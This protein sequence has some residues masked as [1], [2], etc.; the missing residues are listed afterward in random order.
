MS[1]RSLLF[2]AVLPILACTEPVK[3]PGPSPLGMVL[4]P[5]GVTY[6]G[7]SMV[8][9]T[10]VIVE[11]FTDLNGS[12]DFDGCLDDPIAAGEF[13]DEPFD[14]VNGNGRFD[15]VWI[16]GFG[17]LR[18]AQDVHDPIWART[19]VLSQDEQYVAFVAID[20]VGLGSPRIHE[21]K[22]RLAIDGFD[23]DRLV[24]A[25]SHNHQGPDTMGLWGDPITLSNPTSGMDPAYQERV[26]DAIE[27]SVREAAASMEPVDLRVATVL[28][29]DRSPWFNGA[30]FGG[31]N[32]KTKQHGMIND[33]RDPVVVSDQL[34]VMQ[35]MLSSG[36]AAF[37]LTNWSG[38]PETRDSNNN[39][40][41]SDWVGVSREVIEE[42]FGGMALHLPESLGGMQSALGGELPRV[43][44]DG[45]HVFATCEAEA[46]ADPDD[47]DCFGR[48]PGADR[49]DA[50]G[51]SVP[52][53]A[54]K[55]TWDFVTSHGWHIAE[56]TIDIIED[57]PTVSASPIDV[58]TEPI[59]VPIDNFAYQILGP[60]DIFDLGLDDA[61][62]DPALCPRAADSK[63]GCIETQ[64][65]QI[66]V[67]PVGFVAVPGE[68]LPELAWGFPDDAA[69]TLE[70]ADTTARGAGATY[71]PQHR[72]TC[73][74]VSFN[75]CSERTFVDG[76]DCLQLHATPY[77]LSENGAAPPLLEH[78]DTEHRAV[79]GMAD[80]Y[81]SYI[82]PRP[83]F[84]RT[85][86]L[87]WDS[88]GDHYEDTVS[89]SWDFA[90]AI[91]AA[92][93]RI[94]ARRD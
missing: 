60:H 10:P 3:A 9:L 45:V 64:T 31:K 54:E 55:S 48:D 41:S 69:W 44:E 74:G 85:V 72:A 49:V 2:F 46:V 40:I 76:C 75:E 68:L 56:A 53:W 91:Q 15:A 79:L 78:L 88:D 42:R 47:A 62:T 70:A 27:S 38:H 61:V 58:Q 35:G 28:M 80:N 23:R 32:P 90:P 82:I 25:S 52:V 84:H 17:P 8:D 18:P 94:E 77:L 37:T 89:P 22:D 6:A 29:R 1:Y 71:F 59:Y 93:A 30:A 57:A 7:A 83:D 87:L 13:C 50:D 14:D 34:L 11:T 66:R 73:D 43:T 92:Q 63:L 21:A 26:T 16:G 5:D 81:L 24:V 20:V 12:H 86:S 4:L 65:S 51:D 67:G 36:E 39:S 33:G 19:I